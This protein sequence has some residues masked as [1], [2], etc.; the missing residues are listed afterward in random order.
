MWRL[1]RPTGPLRRNPNLAVLASNF[2]STHAA[3]EAQAVRC[4]GELITLFFLLAPHA[5]SQPSRRRPD[6]VL[7]LPLHGYI[8][9]TPFSDALKSQRQLLPSLL[10]V[11]LIAIPTRHVSLDCVACTRPLI[12][13][14][15]CAHTRLSSPVFPFP[16]SFHCSELLLIKAKSSAAASIW[17]YRCLPG[18]RKAFTTYG[19]RSV[20]LRFH[21]P[22]SSLWPTF[23]THPVLSC[24]VQIQPTAQ[25]G[26]RRSVICSCNHDPSPGRLPRMSTARCPLF[27]THSRMLDLTPQS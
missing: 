15:N 5:I 8:T 19:I 1:W 11:Y 14:Q 6:A 27:P 12:D 20:C 9:C 3:T 2:I 18:K 7:Y 17:R 4:Y 16:A 26:L 23:L 25:N 22:I 10:Y 24:P 13:C 21:T